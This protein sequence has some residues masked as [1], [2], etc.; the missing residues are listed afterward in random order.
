MTYEAKA[1]PCRG[2][3]RWCQHRMFR[4]LEGANAIGAT[5]LVASMGKFPWIDTR[6]GVTVYRHIYIYYIYIYIIYIKIY[7][8]SRGILWWLLKNLCV[9]LWKMSST[10]V[11]CVRTPVRTSSLCVRTPVRTLH[12]ACAHLW[13][14]GASPY[15]CARFHELWCLP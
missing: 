11:R 14:Q 8:N 3:A 5:A 2:P 4:R 7:L 12:G 9:R 6:I 1:L 13:V 10:P 15:D